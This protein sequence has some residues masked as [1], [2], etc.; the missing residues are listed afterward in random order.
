MVNGVTASGFEFSYDEHIMDDF[1]ILDAITD[2]IGDEPSR[3]LIGISVFFTKVLGTEGRK[4]LYDHVRT[5]DG[6]VP[7]EAVKSEVMEIL[8]AGGESTK[9]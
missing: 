5:D 9:K 3:Q 6:R 7:I 1:E 8:Q 2:I 4:R